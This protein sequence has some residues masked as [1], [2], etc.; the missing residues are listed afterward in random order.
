MQRSRQKMIPSS[1]ISPTSASLHNTL[2]ELDFALHTRPSH[3]EVALQHRSIPV[4]RSR[5]FN[6]PEVPP[7]PKI[8]RESDASRPV[9]GGFHVVTK[10]AAELA[11]A[12]KLNAQLRERLEG[13][14]KDR[15]GA[16]E[17]AERIKL[18]RDGWRDEIQRV[19]KQA[20]DAEKNLSLA[21]DEA[22]A[23][24][25]TREQLEARESDVESL[26][27][28]VSRLQGAGAALVDE[29]MKMRNEGADYLA[30]GNAEYSAQ[31]RKELDEAQAEIRSLHLQLQSKSNEATTISVQMAALQRQL[32][33]NRNVCNTGPIEPWLQQLEE[34]RDMAIARI[35]ELED[36]AKSRDVMDRRKVANINQLNKEIYQLQHQMQE[37]KATGAATVTISEARQNNADSLELKQL[38]KQ[39]EDLKKRYDDSL[40]LKS[41]DSA[42]LKKR[43]L[44]LCELRKKYAV[45]SSQLRPVQ[46]ELAEV[47]AQALLHMNRRYVQ[48]VGAMRRKMVQAPCKH[49]WTLCLNGGKKCPSRLRMSVSCKLQMKKC[50]RCESR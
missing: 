32:D 50:T 6:V 26:Q 39:H 37:L 22:D 5:S 44:E 41:E 23:H 17:M 24:K 46:T 3:Q 31:M 1:P 13:V 4:A 38:Q 21:S 29:L 42:E 11:A 28:E 18:E 33:T 12:Q 15:D 35:A 34:Q 43:E 8:D 25:A 9:E 2:A 45:A 20:E 16:L 47:Q 40:H 27:Q 48:V 30:A 14:Q 49:H 19:R 10:L 7:R 36:E